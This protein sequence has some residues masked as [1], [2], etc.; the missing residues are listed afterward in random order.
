MTAPAIAV[1]VRMEKRALESRWA[2][3]EWRVASLEPS[4]GAPADAERSRVFGP[5][6]V[7]LYRD[8]AEGYFL[9]TSSGA[10][11]AFVMWRLGDGGLEGEPRVCSVTLSYNEAARLMDAQ[12]RVDA[13]PLPAL[14]ASWLEGFVAEHYRPEPKK[15]RV[16]ASFL[17]PGERGGL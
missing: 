2:D 16:K 12:E 8:E 14:L 7:S 17:A 4:P 3:H 9:N 6:E 13:V 11:R 10:A 1:F 5:I 15:K